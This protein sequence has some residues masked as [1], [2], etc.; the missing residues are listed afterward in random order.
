[1]FQAAGYGG[2]GLGAG[3]IDWGAGG[4]TPGSIRAGQGQSVSGEAIIP[5]MGQVYSQLLGL[6][7]GNYNQILSGY[8]QAQ[9]NLSAGLAGSS[10]G[11]G[12]LYSGIR[13]TLGVGGGG[14]GVAQPAANAIQEQF[15]RSRGDIMS[16]MINSGLGNSTVAAAMQN[17]NAL[18]A[19]RAYGE[20]GNQLANT[21]AG[22]AANIG[23]Q[24]QQAYMQGLGMQSQMANNYLNTLGQYRFQN[25]AGDLVGRYSASS[26]GAG[27]GGGGGGFRGSGGGGSGGGSGMLGW[28]GLGADTGWMN[29]RPAYLGH[30][31]M[32]GGGGDLGFSGGGMGGYGG[33]LGVLPGAMMGL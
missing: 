11:Y 21:A 17:Q 13:D 7:V 27:G 14:W 2:G 29:A 12:N 19:S 15:A 23:L 18:G 5:A 30:A 3:A 25:T 24:Q 20:L 4:V 1:M 16:G 33:D 28:G 8:Q 6:N 26:S 22:Y 10:A 9:S 31:P 32:W